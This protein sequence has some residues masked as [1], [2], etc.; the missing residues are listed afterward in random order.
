MKKPVYLLIFS[1][2][3]VLGDLYCQT[4][5]KKFTN[6][7]SLSARSVSN[8]PGGGYAVSGYLNAEQYIA[9]FKEDGQFVSAKK[10]ASNAGFMPFGNMSFDQQGNA[11][12]V[13]NIA[14]GGGQGQGYNIAK[15]TPFGQCTWVKQ[16]TAYLVPNTLNALMVNNGKITV[17]N[18]GF[19]NSRLIQLDSNGNVIW[20]KAYKF[21]Q[22]LS[23]IINQMLPLPNGEILLCGGFQFDQ[24]TAK[25]VGFIA[26]ID[27]NGNVVNS[28]FYD[29]VV[30][31]DL[32]LLDNGKVAFTA[33][34]YGFYAFDNHH[35]V[36]VVD[37][38]YDL[39]WVKSIPSVA[40]DY[41]LREIEHAGANQFYFS[42]RKPTDCFNKNIMMKMDDFGNVI[43]SKS[44]IA[45][46][47]TYQNSMMTTT[48]KGLIWVSIPADPSGFVLSKIDASGDLQDCPLSTDNPL[49]LIDTTLLQVNYTWQEV[50]KPALID[51]PVYLV[52]DFTLTSDDYCPTYLF[53]S[54]FSIS[55][56]T[57]CKGQVFDISRV[58]GVTGYSQW[59]YGE[60]GT[61]G[62]STL[63]NPSQVVLDSTGD[64]SLTHIFSLGTCQDT[65]QTSIFINPGPLFDLGNTRTICEG[66]SIEIVLPI[67]GNIEWTWSNGSIDTTI[68]VKNAETISLNVEDNLGCSNQDTIEIVAL[69]NPFIDLGTDT[70]VCGN[71]RLM[72][73]TNAVNGL[74]LWQNGSEAQ[75]FN[76]SESGEYAASA[77]NGTCLASDT[78]QVNILTVPSIELGQS[79]DF[80]DSTRLIPTFSPSD[81]TLL[82][83]NGSNLP[84]Q[85]IVSSGWYV[86]KALLGS[87]FTIDSV[88]IRISNCQPSN[89]YIP[90]VFA[91]LGSTE[92]A[93]FRIGY[94]NIQIEFMQIYD[95][96][97]SFVYQDLQ[98]P[99]E[100][101]GKFR[102]KLSPSGVYAIY[103]RYKDLQT[104]NEKMMSGDLTL[105]R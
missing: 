56:D 69:E 31:N 40:S 33:Y 38:S 25:Y 9:R 36:G 18:Y 61:L 13:S 90:N 91:P 46:G 51:I 21:G 104:G 60:N 63:D 59:L 85:D 102:N 81:A 12:T 28:K 103:I 26:R 27:A 80:C 77:T 93:L 100:W 70:S 83:G 35:F 87:C 5:Q 75:E 68:W 19:E 22:F 42:L 49:Q 55:D 64:I 10:F 4:F 79:N 65:T 72:P 24:D 2:L 71:F 32:V 67:G 88:E 15:I 94:Q 45:L 20:L 76:I 58:S 3:F 74:L 17:S 23:P 39:L 50:A 7:Q 105:I 47:Y 53:D 92:N 84:Y 44:T 95:R 62:S 30:F 66:D 73:S 14:N 57:I 98:A 16:D 43:W 29:E 54:G 78:V 41:N 11:Y 52:S 86:T 97:G 99:F 8:I 6:P 96:W 89:I 82:W 101:D 1:L 37:S 34:F 48:D